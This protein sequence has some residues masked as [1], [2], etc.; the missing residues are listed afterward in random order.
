[1]YV[2]I[3]ICIKKDFLDKSKLS[4][5]LLETSKIILFSV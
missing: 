1:M 3:Y 5:F 2:Y 4:E